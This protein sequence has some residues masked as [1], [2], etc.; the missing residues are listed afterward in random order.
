MAI[1]RRRKYKRD[2]IERPTDERDSRAKSK[3]F[4]ERALVYQV[5]YVGTLAKTPDWAQ[6][7]GVAVDGAGN[8]YVAGSAGV[9]FAVTTGPAFAGKPVDALIARFDT[10]HTSTH[11]YRFAHGCSPPF[12]E[13]FPFL[14]NPGSRVCGPS[15]C[16]G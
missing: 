1:E 12:R 8:A 5:K 3:G 15:D 7:N 14:R 6:L 4:A 9:A 10:P 2:H 16:S 13:S 11:I